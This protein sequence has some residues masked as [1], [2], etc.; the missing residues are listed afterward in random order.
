MFLVRFPF[1]KFWTFKK[2]GT[3]RV[4]SSKIKLTNRN[5]LRRAG[6]ESRTSLPKKPNRL[7]LIRLEPSRNETN[8][9]TLLWPNP[10]ASLAT[11]DRICSINFSGFLS[12]QLF[13]SWVQYCKARLG[14][15]SCGE[16]TIWLR[17]NSRSCWVDSNMS[18]GEP[19]RAAPLSP[20]LLC[21]H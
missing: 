13:P 1:P 6:R 10:S 3:N 17:P 16:P 9:L 4:S 2:P 14:S 19:H 7:E 11:L 8:R 15:K 12:V 18:G 21:M 5:W 20:L